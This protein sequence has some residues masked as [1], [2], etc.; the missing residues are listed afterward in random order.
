[1]LR[2]LRL[3]TLLVTRC[4]LARR[5]R[6]VARRSRGV[7]K[8]RYATPTRPCF[9]E[10]DPFLFASVGEEVDGVPLSVLS[11][12]T[13][14]GLDPRDEAARLSHLTREAAADQLA[15]MIARLSDQRWTLSEAHGIAAPLIAHLPT[16]TTAGKPDP[17][18]TGAVPSRSVGTGFLLSLLL[19]AFS[20]KSQ[21]K[22]A[23][24]LP[25]TL[26]HPASAGGGHRVG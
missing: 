21:N 19:L 5:S 2:L 7:V 16:S 9:P 13:R 6:G 1:M 4:S 20:D 3:G 26:R 24:R 23:R 10:F 18:A 15:R 22:G 17:L 12:L 25:R 8:C 14:L 11:A